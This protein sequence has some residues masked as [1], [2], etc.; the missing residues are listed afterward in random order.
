MPKKNAM[1]T[2][3]DPTVVAYKSPMN[4]MVKKKVKKP[5]V[6]KASYYNNAATSIGK[7]ESTKSTDY[8]SR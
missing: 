8:T 1:P 5:P 3:Y 2:F 6:K 7:Y 4:E